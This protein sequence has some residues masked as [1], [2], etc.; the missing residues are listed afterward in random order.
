MAEKVCQ[1]DRARVGYSVNRPTAP[2]GVGD[3]AAKYEIKAEQDERHTP[4]HKE[5]VP[6]VEL[7]RHIG[8]TRDDGIFPKDRE[9]TPE[10]A[11]RDQKRGLRPQ[12]QSLPWKA[13]P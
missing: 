12:H 1:K 3:E 11:E 10:Q 7:V 2:R 13:G 6:K 8:L 5:F 9:S 4:Q